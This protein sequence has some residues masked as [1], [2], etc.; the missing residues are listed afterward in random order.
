[1]NFQLLIFLYWPIAV[2]ALVFIFGKGI[3]RRIPPVLTIAF[4]IFSMML[5]EK[6]ISGDPGYMFPI[7]HALYPFACILVLCI[8][9][10]VEYAFWKVY[11]YF[12]KKK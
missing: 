7:A 10:I 8:L 9:M 1:M 6:E 3:K 2:A 12:T 5:I 4:A 11:V